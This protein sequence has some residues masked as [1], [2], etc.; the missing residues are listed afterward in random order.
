MDVTRYNGG[1][2]FSTLSKILMSEYETK[3]ESPGF[4]QSSL[5]F[6]FV[7]VPILVPF[8]CPLQSL[9]IKADFAAAPATGKHYWEET[10]EWSN[11]RYRVAGLG[12]KMCHFLCLKHRGI[13]HSQPRSS[14]LA[15]GPCDKYSPIAPVWIRISLTVFL[16]NCIFWTI[17]LYWITL[18]SL[19]NNA[20]L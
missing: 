15:S 19:L 4:C 13:P 9:Y 12:V 1:P 7:P 5:Q 20:F 17:I 14:K 2:R 10:K 6:T 8:L 11:S 16:F 3:T 18:L